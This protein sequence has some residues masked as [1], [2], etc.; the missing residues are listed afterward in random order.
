MPPNAD[1]PKAASALKVAGFI[2]SPQTALKWCWLKQV[3]KG[4][5]HFASTRV[6]HCT[7]QG[8][9]SDGCTDEKATKRVLPEYGTSF[10]RPYVSGLVAARQ[11]DAFADAGGERHDLTKVN[12]PPENII[13]ATVLIDR[14]GVEPKRP[15][16]G[17]TEWISNGC[18]KIG[19]GFAG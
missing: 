6:A 14:G 17:E 5:K 1:P 13:R 16:Y 15:T 19:V 7:T 18:T 12:K 10:W 9:R 3:P 8:E 11:I 2:L 4:E